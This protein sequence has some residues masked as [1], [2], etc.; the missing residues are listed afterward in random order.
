MLNQGPFSA[1]FFFFKY[2][3]CTILQ[4]AGIRRCTT[5]P[6]P[7]TFANL[8][9]ASLIHGEHSYYVAFYIEITNNFNVTLPILPYTYFFTDPSSGGDSP[10]FIVG[11]PGNVGSGLQICQYI[12][13]I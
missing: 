11:D 12:P 9:T 3:A 4:A 10:F 7:V 8:P 6:S 5:T 1:N 13:A 2:S